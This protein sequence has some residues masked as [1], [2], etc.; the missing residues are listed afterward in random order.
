MAVRDPGRLMEAA[1]P[2]LC[3]PALAVVGGGAG[4]RLFAGG[5][6]VA[7]DGPACCCCSCCC[8]DVPKG[9]GMGGTPG[10]CELRAAAIAD[11]GRDF[12]GIGG[13]SAKKEDAERFSAG[14][15]AFAVLGVSVDAVDGAA[16]GFC[17][18][19]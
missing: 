4:V 17:A 19:E 2:G 11:P 12:I 8:G 3:P 6:G 16:G 7:R 5:G 13:S 14:T 9:D 1:D 18:F 10:L 15:F